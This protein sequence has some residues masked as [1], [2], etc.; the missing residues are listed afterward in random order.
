MSFNCCILTKQSVIYLDR[1]E[2]P[3]GTKTQKYIFFPFELFCG[4]KQNLINL[5]NPV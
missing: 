1:N 2:P 3:K 5:V 4:K